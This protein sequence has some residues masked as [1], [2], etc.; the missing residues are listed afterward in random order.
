MNQIY[1][2]AW[3]PGGPK[4]SGRSDVEGGDGSKAAVETVELSGVVVDCVRD[5]PEGGRLKEEET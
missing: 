1:M 4:S 5:G 3:Y 2:V